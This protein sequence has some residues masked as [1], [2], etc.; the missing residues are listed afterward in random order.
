MLVVKVLHRD[1]RCQVDIVQKNKQ[2]YCF[3]LHHACW[4]CFQLTKQ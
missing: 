3:W 2:L 4:N 1:L